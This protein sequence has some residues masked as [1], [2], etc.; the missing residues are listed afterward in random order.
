MNPQMIPAGL[1]ALPLWAVLRQGTIT[2]PARSDPAVALGLIAGLVAG[3]GTALVAFQLAAI[4][5][6]GGWPTYVERAADGRFTAVCLVAAEEE[7][8]CRR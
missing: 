1:C 4:A 3:T 5:P 8:G 6:F 7:L 2:Q